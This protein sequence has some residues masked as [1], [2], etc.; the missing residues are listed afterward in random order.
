MILHIPSHLYAK[1]HSHLFQNE[2][3]QAAFL[4]GTAN[5]QSF[6]A[7]DIYLVPPEGWAVQMD[8]YLEMSNVERARAMSVAR[9]G[10]WAIV[11][12][13]SH[14]GAGSDVWFSPSDIAG[15][16]NYAQYARWKLDRRPYVATVWG[17]SSV[18][19]VCWYGDFSECHP[20]ES[21]QIAGPHKSQMRPQNSWFKEPRAYRR[22]EPR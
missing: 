15:I 7:K 12:C 6:E 19:A 16:T 3:E 14:P 8:I 20:V 10:G 11:D 21:V 22:K 2:L 9:H 4:L 17:E 5:E 18:D 1:L 13:H